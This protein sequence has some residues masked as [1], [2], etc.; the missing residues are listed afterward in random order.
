MPGEN[1][2]APL[3]SPGRAVDELVVTEQHLKLLRHMYVRWDHTETGAP[4]IE[5]KRPYGNS[6]V[7]ADIR[8][9]LDMD[10]D[11]MPDEA[12][13]DLHRQTQYAL[14]IALRT[15]AFE[16]GLY[17]CPSYGEWRHVR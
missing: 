13:L 12:A 6:D 8:D 9:I 2:R 16:T 10:D 17:V 5:P 4:A 1:E 14:E 15:G 3:A 11:A 7:A